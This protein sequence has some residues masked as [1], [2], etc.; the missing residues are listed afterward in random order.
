MTEL[1][2]EPP[3]GKVTAD[4]LRALLRRKYPADQYAMLYEVRDA[5]GHGASNSADVLMIGLWPS[6][7][8][9]LEGMEIKV[10][11]SDW[12]RELKKPAKAEAFVPYCD[13][14]WIVTASPDIVKPEELPKTW[15]L[16][17]MRGR[18]LTVAVQA[19][20]L[21]PKPVDRSLLAAM[22]KRATDTAASSP[23]VR[24]TIL[25]QAKALEERFEERVK[26]RTSHVQRQLEA[27]QKGVAEFEAR[28][29]I[30]INAYNGARLGDAVKR[31]M[32]GDDW[33]VKH[34]LQAFERTRKQIS[35]LHAWF[36]KHAAEYGVPLPDQQDADA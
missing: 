24:S 33:Q 21:T 20:T 7:G 19:P 23:E 31:V 16:M 29:G 9:M 10:S 8:C 6:R 32:S 17:T 3:A 1:P 30:S 4:E 28:A 11:R 5:A 34:H 36:E 22:L 35:D 12:L 14:W 13:R 26:G 2:L 25:A 18:G 27:L 15:G